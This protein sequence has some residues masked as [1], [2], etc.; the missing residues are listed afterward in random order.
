VTACGDS[1]NLRSSWSRQVNSASGDGSSIFD[2][3]LLLGDQS[4]HELGTFLFVGLDTLVKQHL[5]DLR[6]GPLFLLSDFAERLAST[7]KS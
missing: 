5:A 2:P 1:N 7:P 4:L 6:D 3:S